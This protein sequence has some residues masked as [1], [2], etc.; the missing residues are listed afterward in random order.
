MKDQAESLR[1][2][3]RQKAKNAARTLA[4][5]SGKGGVG[6]SN[7]SSNMAVILAK[8]GYK[9]L[10]FDLDIGMGNVH[11][12]LGG[13][14]PKTMGDFIFNGEPLSQIVQEGPFG[15]SYV[16]GGNG[17]YDA[18]EMDGNTVKMFLAGFQMF[19]ETYDYL[20][21]DM[22]A[23]AG[24]SLLSILLAADDLIVV[25]TPEP[26]AVMDAYSIMKLAHLQ[27][28]NTRFLVMCN[29]TDNDK[30]GQ[31]TFL[32]LQQAMRRFLQKEID[33]LGI[34]PED[35]HVR[36]AVLD[37]S[38]VYCVYPRSPVSVKL[39]HAVDRLTGR[40]GLNGEMKSDSFIS[41]LRKLFYGKS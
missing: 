41:R 22:A 32:R 35:R 16:A 30:Q 34:L 29:R 20:I 15:V 33:L 37:Y 26:T 28:E 40:N 1:L 12:L 4:V 13:S 19:Q 39:E 9:V 18:V 11:L 25:T 3:M 10:V 8:K 14:A 6:K 23:G 38:P 17:L 7:I 21:F 5:V 2:K 24:Q 36:K 31:E 27:N